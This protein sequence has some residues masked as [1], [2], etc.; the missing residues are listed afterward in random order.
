MIKECPMYSRDYIFTI[1]LTLEP[2]SYEEVAQH[3][4]WKETM[5]QEYESIM[6]MKLGL[7]ESIVMKSSNNHEMDV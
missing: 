1:E 7:C 2:T 3:P 4:R 5:K 6:K